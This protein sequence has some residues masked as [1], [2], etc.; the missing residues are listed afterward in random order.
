MTKGLHAYDKIDAS[1]LF[2]R[3]WL[4]FEPT[5]GG[6]EVVL[7]V[8][9]ASPNRAEVGFGYTEW[10]RARG[11]IRLR[12][13]N[14][15]GFGEK[16]ELLLAASDAERV[17]EA[18]LSGDRLLVAGFGYRIAGYT[19][20]DKPRFFDGAG[21]EIN[22]GRF[23]RDGVDLLLRTER[24]RRVLLEGG[25]RFG[26]VK[27]TAR[28]GLE[29]IAPP[30]TDQVGAVFGRIVLDGLDDLRWPEHGAR[31]ALAGEWS[32]AGLGAEREYWLAGLE[33]RAARQ[34]GERVTLQGD[35]ALSLSGDDLPVYDWYRLGGEVLV[36][37]YRRE[38]LK[39]AQAMAFAAS[40]RVRVLGQLRAL[41]RGG[42]GNVFATTDQ[43]GFDQ[44]RWGVATGFYHPSPI[45]PVSIEFAV[46]DGGET[47]TTLSVGWP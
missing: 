15:F 24:E 17:L 42:A 35:L 27:T 12:N 18:S 40:V 21:E 26:R 13:Q 28:G 20:L 43:I 46:H 4:E 31:L 14:T 44:L 39:G 19:N 5:D 32:S 36:P 7:R 30:A 34:L 1:H 29:A 22:R 25:A 11:S 37:G 41:L 8:K 38:E 23:Q 45:G 33:L 47:L 2:E 9:D 16:V 3:T 6:V 10:E